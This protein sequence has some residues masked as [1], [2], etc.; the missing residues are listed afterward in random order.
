MVGIIPFDIESGQLLTS[1]QK[2]DEEAFAYIFK[3]FYS[4]LFN[5]A[6][7]ILRDEEQ[8]NDVVQDTFCRLYCQL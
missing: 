1:L 3:T 4:P 6:G 8:A 7:R 2:G 5:Y